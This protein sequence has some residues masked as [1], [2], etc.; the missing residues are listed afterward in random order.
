[1]LQFAEFCRNKIRS[2]GKTLRG[3]GYM[4]RKEIPHAQSASFRIEPDKQICPIYD[5]TGIRTFPLAPR[6]KM[7]FQVLDDFVQ[8]HIQ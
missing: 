5:A 1:M 2:P 6:W 7:G 3:G 8:E 4:H